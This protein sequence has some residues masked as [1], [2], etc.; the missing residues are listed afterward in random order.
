M[1]TFF[2]HIEHPACNIWLAKQLPLQ[3]INS[4]SYE[5][6]EASPKYR[7]Q[8]LDWI[9]F[10]VEQGFYPVWQRFR[11]ALQQRNA[12]LKK[13]RAC[14]HSEVRVWD[15]ELAAMGFEIDQYRKAIIKEIIP[16]F[17][18]IMRDLT[19]IKAG[20]QLQYLPGWNEEKALKEALDHS[21]ERDM[22]FGHTTVGPH[23]AELE[24]LVDGVA[25]KTV[26]SRGQ[27]KLF[28][29]ALLMARAKLLSQREGRRCLFLIDD[30]GSELD[31]GASTQLL[32]ALMGLGSQVIVTCID[33]NPLLR[34]LRGA[35]N[36]Q[37][38]IRNGEMCLK[39]ST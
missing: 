33:P 29:C 15:N 36:T 22:A 24:F 3:L 11:R 13:G 20:F 6:L 39:G 14:S 7:R 2:Q 10:H 27:S 25:A 18:E 17:K 8:F 31:Q 9:L 32:E 37:F 12:A 19:K 16:I 26:L 30:L 34:V 38:E 5:I 1:P 28:I 35:E 21:F 4:E 23:R